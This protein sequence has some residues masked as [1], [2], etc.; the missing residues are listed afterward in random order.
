MTTINPVESA[1]S[2]TKTHRARDRFYFCAALINDKI[3]AEPVMAVDEVCATTN[4]TEK[5]GV[6]PAVINA[7]STGLGWHDVKGTGN[8]GTEKV[9]VTL[10]AE[11]ILK[12]TGSAWKGTYRNWNV[13]AS[14][15]SACTVGDTEY[16]DDEIVAIIL[17]DRVAG[18]ND[19]KPKLPQNPTILF[20]ALENVSPVA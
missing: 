20:S 18:T 17:T 1:I 19:R 11:Q 7:G 13:F 2:E 6:A 12:R 16:E 14:G 3:V 10:S 4:F 15:V 5:F 8:L 9:S